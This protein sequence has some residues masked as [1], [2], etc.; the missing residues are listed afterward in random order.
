ML[1]VIEKMRLI[2]GTELQLGIKV[3]TVSIYLQVPKPDLL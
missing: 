1:N 2:A 3:N